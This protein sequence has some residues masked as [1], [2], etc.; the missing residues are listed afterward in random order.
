VPGGLVQG[1]SP[2]E[3]RRAENGHRGANFGQRVLIPCTNS[4]WIRKTR[5]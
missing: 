3:T 4:P 5:Q 1:I 2:A